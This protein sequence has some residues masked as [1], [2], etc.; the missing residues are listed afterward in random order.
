MRLSVISLLIMMMECQLH[1]APKA[2]LFHLQEI[3]VYSCQKT[4]TVRPTASPSC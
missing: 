1:E 4:L 2:E 3:L